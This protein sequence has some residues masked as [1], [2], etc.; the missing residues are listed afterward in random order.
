MKQ[1]EVAQEDIEK[2]SCKTGEPS[3]MLDKRLHAFSSLQLSS[4]TCRYGRGLSLD[5]SDFPFQSFSVQNAQENFSPLNHSA[6]QTGLVISDLF[7]ACHTHSDIIRQ[8]LF[9]TLPTPDYFEAFHELL[10]NR[11]I[12]VLVPRGWKGDP[13]VLDQPCSNQQFF[14]LL[15]VA[16]PESSLSLINASSRK[17]LTTEMIE[18]VATENAS[19]A[20][21]SFQDMSGYH[22]SFKRAS[23]EANAGI[24]WTDGVC[25]GS[26]VHSGISTLLKGSGAHTKIQSMFIGN[27]SQQ[28]NLSSSAIHA[29][30]QTQSDILTVGA[31]FDRSKAICRGNLR[32]QKEAR[33]SDGYQKYD[34]LLLGE[35]AEADS[36]PQL[37]IDTNEVRCSHG[38]TITHPDQEKLFYLMSRG[39]PE[40]QAI[41]LLAEGLFNPLL[42]HLPATFQ[43]SA[44]RLISQH[45]N[46]S[47]H[48]PITTY[49][50]V[51][52]GHEEEK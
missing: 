39:I 35:E 14:H 5:L 46:S 43:L 3:W 15:V 41:Q 21:S 33:H 40:T 9:S 26:I 13:L 4:P 27:K 11:G 8:H 16:E 17:G 7:R 12:F 18:I 6:Q 24:S 38:A 36:V 48:V 51:T 1:P 23:A 28:L 32:I 44:R 29:A 31:L 50:T 47:A 10:L 2:L 22:L 42:E 52:K 49:G 45:L 20:Y 25:G 34:I 19:V 30:P 37:E